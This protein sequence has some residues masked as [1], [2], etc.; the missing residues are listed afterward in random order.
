MEH[1]CDG[2]NTRVKL[3]TPTF[4]PRRSPSFF[5]KTFPFFLTQTQQQTA[6]YWFINES[7]GRLPADKF[8]LASTGLPKYHP[9]DYTPNAIKNFA[10]SI[11]T[12][13]SVSPSDPF[14]RYHRVEGLLAP[15]YHLAVDFD[16]R[17]NLWRMFDMS[18]AA[19]ASEN[20]PH[21]KES[22]KLVTMMRNNATWSEMS[23]ESP[24]ARF[25]ELGLSVPNLRFFADCRYQAFMKVYD[26]R[27]QTEEEIARKREMPWSEYNEEN[28]VV[29]FVNFLSPS[30][31]PALPPSASPSP[32]LSQTNT[33]THL[34]LSLSLS[35]TQTPTAPHSRIRKSFR[36]PRDLRFSF[37]HPRPHKLLQA[38]VVEARLDREMLVPLGLIAVLRRQ[39]VDEG[40]NNRACTWATL[41][42][43]FYS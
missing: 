13:T 35:H 25:P 12:N 3:D 20:H 15:N 38:A 34:S 36:A 5:S 40:R 42:T 26:T 21:P 43:W 30:P 37:S 1:S 14:M 18:P 24:H 39:M 28:V 23:E 32:S 29:C 9:P 7:W 27:G 4:V 31:P 33:H 8:I 6:W 11:H 10:L 2:F 22:T 17:N 19:A 16:M 41:G